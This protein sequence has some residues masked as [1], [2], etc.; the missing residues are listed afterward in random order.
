M[1]PVVRKSALSARVHNRGLRHEARCF[2][3][4][5]TCRLYL[6]ATELAVQ[7]FACAS[8]PLPSGYGVPVQRA[9][10]PRELTPYRVRVCRPIRRLSVAPQSGTR[11]LLLILSFSV[12]ATLLPPASTVSPLRLDSFAMELQGHPN[13]LSVAYVLDGIRSGFRKGHIGKP[14]LRSAKQ[15]KKSAKEHP[16]IID[17]YL[18][19]EVALGRVAGFFLH[20]PIE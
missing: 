9:A 8:C 1:R 13:Q 4:D 10:G 16:A 17:E 3:S 5:G 19:H 18:A 6:F 14:R 2:A 15:N 20:P 11:G 12:S 7:P